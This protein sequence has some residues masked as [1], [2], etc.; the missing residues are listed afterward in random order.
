MLRR[1]S[2]VLGMAVLLSLVIPLKALLKH[3]GIDAALG[4]RDLEL[5]VASVLLA[6]L[7]AFALFHDAQLARRIP[8]W[9][10]W[11]AVLALCS[12]LFLLLHFTW[13]LELAAA[14]AKEALPP[15]LPHRAVLAA[16]ELAARLGVLVSLVGVLVNLDAV[17]D[18][19]EPPVKRRKK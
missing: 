17:P 13:S 19:D 12:V 11:V 10:L 18:P 15:T 8:R 2:V 16:I 9:N 3:S 14:Y 4:V 7:P 6:L 1:V 5:V